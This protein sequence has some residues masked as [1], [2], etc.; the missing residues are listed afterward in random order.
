MSSVNSMI[1]NVSSIFNTIGTVVDGMADGNRM[2]LKE[3]AQA[4]SDKSGSNPQDVLTFVTYFARNTDLGYVS[5]GKNGG[6]IK[7][8]KKDKATVTTPTPSTAEDK[9]SSSSDDFADLDLDM[10]FPC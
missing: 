7:G 10:W 5:R 3:L 8:Q 9:S 2:Q 6:F 4:V 1:Q